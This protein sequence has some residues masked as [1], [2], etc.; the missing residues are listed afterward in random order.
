VDVSYW[1]KPAVPTRNLT[2]PLLEVDRLFRG[3][4][5]PSHLV[6]LGWAAPDGIIRARL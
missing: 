6:M 4:A 2:F 5:G 1:H 3:G